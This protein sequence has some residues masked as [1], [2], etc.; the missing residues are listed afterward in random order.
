LI[1]AAAIGVVIVVPAL[2]HGDDR[3]DEVIA[4]RV[5]R[6]VATGAV[7][8]R[9][10]VD[11]E[12]PVPEEYSAHEETPNKSGPAADGKHG[13]GVGDN[14]DDVPLVEEPEFREF[15]KIGQLIPVSFVMPVAQNPAHMRPPKSVVFGGVD[16]VLLIRKL[17]VKTMVS[18]PPKR[19]FLNCRAGEEH[20]H[21]L[22]KPVH[23]ISSVRKVTMKST[24]HREHA[25]IITS[26]AECYPFPAEGH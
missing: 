19:A 8:V 7:D 9:Q 22:P 23:L 15:R 5:R 18:G 25:E 4:A 21:E 1:R 20:H 14:W 17:M 26:D 24:R 2:S 3:E 6:R 16:V 12:R 13:N 11:R 10:R